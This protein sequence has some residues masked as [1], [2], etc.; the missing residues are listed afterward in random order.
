[1]TK[2]PAAQIRLQP[3]VPTS[4]LSLQ[5]RH[6]DKP[7]CAIAIMPSSGVEAAVASAGIIDPTANTVKAT[8]KRARR[9]FFMTIELAACCKEI[10]DKMIAL[11]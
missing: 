8:R 2:P 10:H 5:S 4:P 9:Q 3:A 1:M 7:G 6:S 11:P